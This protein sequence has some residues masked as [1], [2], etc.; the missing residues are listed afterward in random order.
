M[1][2]EIGVSNLSKTT[3]YSIAESICG[4]DESVADFVS[5]AGGAAKCVFVLG[6]LEPNPCAGG[7]EQTAT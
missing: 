7:I 4:Y 3:V 2:I 1:E 6:C 5:G